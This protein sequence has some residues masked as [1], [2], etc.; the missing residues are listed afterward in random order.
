MPGCLPAVASSGSNSACAAEDVIQS[1]W[2][3]P[4]LSIL[5][6]LSITS[7]LNHGHAYHLYVHDEIENVPH[8][9]IIKPA[10]EILPASAIF[11]YCDHP[12]YAG[13]SNF[14]RYK[15]L[16]L[17]GGWWADADVICL[18]PFRFPEAY[19][20][21]SELHRGETYMNATVI[22]SPAGSPAMDFAVHVCN[23]KNSAE[24]QWGDTGSRL[25]SNLVARF[26]WS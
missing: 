6:R 5:E 9:T 16:L 26:D 18:K 15:L 25:I 22:K 1:L 21:S 19:V 20:F 3:G 10:D 7:F 12:S 23:A 11:R 13:F 14:F 24:L 17:K 8:G 4:R 2:I